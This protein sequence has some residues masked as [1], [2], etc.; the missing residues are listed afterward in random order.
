[1]KKIICRLKINISKIE[2]YLNIN[3]NYD[4]SWI[5]GKIPEIFVELNLQENNINGTGLFV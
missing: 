5:Q 2:K 1:M 4:S 3:L